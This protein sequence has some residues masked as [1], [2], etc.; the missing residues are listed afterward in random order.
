VVPMGFDGTTLTLLHHPTGRDDVRT[1]DW[2]VLAVPAAPADAL[3][4]ALRAE[5]GT[6]SFTVERVGDC[7]APRRAHAAVVE[8]QR[9][10][11]HVPVP[12]GRREAAGGKVA[13]T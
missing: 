8:G 9:A 10:G 5:A 7:V 13:R 11:A 6:G 4:H 12:L 2:V 3:F 1:P